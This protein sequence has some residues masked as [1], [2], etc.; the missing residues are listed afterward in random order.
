VPL[1]LS[2]FTKAEKNW[3]RA[4]RPGQ[5]TDDPTKPASPPVDGVHRAA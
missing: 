5:T 1:Y 2:F 4:A 3:N